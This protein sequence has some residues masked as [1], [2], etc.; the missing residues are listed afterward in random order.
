MCGRSSVLTVNARIPCQASKEEGVET[1]SD[2]C[3]SVGQILPL[4]EARDY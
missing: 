3:N 2:E 4:V 1:K